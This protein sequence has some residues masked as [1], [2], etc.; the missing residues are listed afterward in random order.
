M[1]AAASRWFATPTTSFCCV[2]MRLR[3]TALGMVQNWTTSVPARASPDKTH[4]VDATQ[5]G[6]FDFLGFHF[7]RGYRWPR[8]KSLKKLKDK[9][10]GLTKRT[11][12]LS[13]ATIISDVDR[14]LVGWFGYFKHSYKTTFAPWTAGFACACAA[15]SASVTALGGGAWART[16]SAGQMLSLLTMGCSRYPL[17]MPRPVNPLGGEPPTE[18][19]MREIRSYGSEGGA[20]G[21]RPFLPLSRVVGSPDNT[22]PGRAS[23]NFALELFQHHGEVVA[24]IPSCAI[25]G[26]TAVP[27]IPVPLVFS[28]PLD[29]LFLV[30]NRSF[31]PDFESSAYFL[32]RGGLLRR[33]RLHQVEIFRDFVVGGQ[34]F[35]QKTPEGRFDKRP[36]LGDSSP[37]EESASSAAEGSLSN[38]SLNPLAFLSISCR[39]MLS[40]SSGTEPFPWFF[41]LSGLWCCE[42]HSR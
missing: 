14:T 36:I 8:Q 39:R 5:R 23:S 19:R 24:C 30:G 18:S 27:E 13:L 41:P 35:H 33:N 1:A 7:E 4:I 15:Y 20:P 31:T 9:I 40:R 16:I 2:A 29:N 17:P 21:N 28:C 10:R 11:N 37:K 25:F 6:G 32:Q 34:L 38:L 3:P 26:I 22:H 42:F 12:G